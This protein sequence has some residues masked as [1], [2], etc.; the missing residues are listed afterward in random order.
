LEERAGDPTELTTRTYYR[1][2]S[3]PVKSV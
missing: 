2:G 1:Q 3:G